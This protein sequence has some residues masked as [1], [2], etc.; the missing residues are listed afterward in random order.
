M[1]AYTPFDRQFVRAR[2]TQY[3]DQLQRH[4]SGE[5]SGEEFRP[6]RLQN[7]WYVQRHAPMLR[8]AVPYGELSSRQLR[9]LARIARE[10]D[11]QDAGQAP[12]AA[13][14]ATSAH[15]RTCSSTGSACRQRRRDGPAGRRGHARHPDQRQLHPQH[16]HRRA[17]RHRARRS[18]GPAPLLRAAAPVEHA[19]PRVRLPATQV[20][21]RGHRRAGRPRRHRLARHRPHAAPQCRWRS[22]LSCRGGRRHGPHAARRH[23]VPG[24]CALAADP[25]LHRG[26]GAGLQPL[27]PARQPVQVAHQDPGQG[28]G[29]R[30]VDDRERRVCGPAGRPRH[31]AAAAGRTGRV[32]ACFVALPPPA[33]LAQP[34]A[35]PS[36]CPPT[37]AGCSATCTRTS[38]P[39]TAR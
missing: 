17:G 4:L 33:T 24:L 11:L 31:A 5:L 12:N 2:A 3:R 28:R 38:C 37:A 21:D 36:P 8:V 22:G 18:G 30:F 23:R 34:H 7:G 27:R 39:A 13:A 20:Q 9:Q 10:F 32:A 29:P 19:A 16:H 15:A 6:L 1:Y 25:R 26:R 35:A 14:S